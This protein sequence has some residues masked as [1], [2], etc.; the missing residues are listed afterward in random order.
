MQAR[1]VPIEEL[2]KV[3]HRAKRKD[4]KSIIEWFLGSNAPA[5]QIEYDS[6][7]YSTVRSAS[8]SVYN[9]AKQMGANIKVV[10]KEGKL[11][12]IKPSVYDEITKK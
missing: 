8:A 11:Y 10:V 12:I 5:L 7:E 6:K 4:L 9:V 1:E 3:L 2:R